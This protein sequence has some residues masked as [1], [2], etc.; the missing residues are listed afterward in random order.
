M[1]FIL[2]AIS[3]VTMIIITASAYRK[4]LIFRPSNLETQS[5]ISIILYFFNKGYTED[6]KVTDKG[7]KAIKSGKLYLADQIKVINFHLFESSLNPDEKSAF[8]AIETDDGGK[9]TLVDDYYSDCQ[10]VKFM[11]KLNVQQEPKYQRNLKH[12]KMEAF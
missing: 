9:G 4:K 7:M 3:G 5:L 10:L 1:S 6:Y 12:V 11:E 8:Y 2:I